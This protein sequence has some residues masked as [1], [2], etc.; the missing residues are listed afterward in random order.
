MAGSVALHC[1]V[2]LINT[3]TLQHW[4]ES[5]IFVDRE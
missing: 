1:S 2:G 4:P 3:D 5:L